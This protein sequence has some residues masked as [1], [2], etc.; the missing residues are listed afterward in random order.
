MICC[1][2]CGEDFGT[3]E[4]TGDFFERALRGG[5]ADALEAASG[6]MFEAFE[7]ER[8]M[9]A[10]LGRNDAREFRRGLRCRR[11]GGVREAAT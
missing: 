9:R 4:E 5:E 3:A 7:R 2:C 11:S 8:K 10:A 6:E 1:C